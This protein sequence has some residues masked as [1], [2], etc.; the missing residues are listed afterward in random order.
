MKA[1]GY[2][3]VLLDIMMPELDGIQ[4]LDKLIKGVIF[5]DSWLST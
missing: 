3:L 2:N 5:R 4:V 1:T